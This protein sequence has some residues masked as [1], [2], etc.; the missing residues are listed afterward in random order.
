[1]EKMQKELNSCLYNTVYNS[2]NYY[3]NKVVH[4]FPYNQHISV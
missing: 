1:M 4:Q 2:I 3:K